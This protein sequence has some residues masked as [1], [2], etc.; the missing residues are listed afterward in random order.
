MPDIS[1][2]I[3]AEGG[4]GLYQRVLSRCRFLCLFGLLGSYVWMQFYP[5]SSKLYPLFGRFLAF[6]VP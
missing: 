5:L 4:G 1:A 6:I 3:F 2:D